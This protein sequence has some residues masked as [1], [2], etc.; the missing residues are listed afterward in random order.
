VKDRVAG[1]WRSKYKSLEH[2]TNQRL[3]QCFQLPVMFP[4]SKEF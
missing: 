1:V 2:S 3:S 4:K